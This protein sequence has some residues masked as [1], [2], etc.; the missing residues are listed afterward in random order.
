MSHSYDYLVFIGRFQPVHLG[1][2]A[3]MREALQRA[4]KLIVLCGA[5]GSARRMRNPWHETER[6]AMIRA[7]LDAAENARVH[8]GA[9]ADYPDDGD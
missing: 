8:I 6:Y 3:M 2:I 1:H 4:D 5:A 7:A 9:V